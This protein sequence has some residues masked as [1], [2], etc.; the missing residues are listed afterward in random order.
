MSFSSDIKTEIIAN[1]DDYDILAMLSAFTKTIGTLNFNI[2]GVKVTLKTE[3]NP[4][5]RLI[6]SNIKKL[7]A[8][9]CD[10]KV[11]HNNNLR[12]KNIYEVIIGED[13][14]SRFCQDTRTSTNPFDFDNGIFEDLINTDSKKISFLQGAFLGTGFCYDPS[15]MYHLEIIFKKENVSN[16]VKDILQLFQIKSSI[17]ERNENYVLYMKEAETIS[18]FLSLIKAYNSVLKFENIRAFKDIKNNVNRRFN[19]ET[20]NLNKTIDASLKQKIIIEKI[21]KTIGL[22][23]LDPA[24]LELAYARIENP[25][26]SLKQLGEMMNPKIS[27]SGV[28]Y[29][30]NKLKKI[31][32]EL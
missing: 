19:F 17:F 23:S 6:F 20:A 29:R 26:I 18:D 10:I 30:L 31:A 13:V 21:E 7:Y 22:E 12:K 1:L 9:D 25:D 15:S 24:L 4:I 27:K 28:S 32:D 14:A 16:Q 11:R 5:A 3:S 2:N 8:Y